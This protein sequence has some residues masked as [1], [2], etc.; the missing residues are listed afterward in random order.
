[1]LFDEKSIDSSKYVSKS[2]QTKAAVASKE[3]LTDESLTISGKEDRSERQAA[4]KSTMSRKNS[5]VPPE[6]LLEALSSQNSLKEQLKQALSLASTRSALILETETRLAEARGRIIS[7]EK[8]L[9]DRETQLKA[10]KSTDK[11]I[12]ER[13]EDSILSITI[14]SLQNLLLEKDTTLSKYQ[15]LLKA[16]RQDRTKEVETQAKEI[17]NLKQNMENL[18]EE[19]RKKKK[20]T[21]NLKEQS[22][23]TV[24]KLSLQDSVTTVKKKSSSES[25]D[26]ST[27]SEDKHQFSMHVLYKPDKRKRVEELEASVERMERQ[28]R[29]M[30]EREKIWEK[31]LV[32]LENENLK[33]KQQFQSTSAVVDEVNENI[34]Y[35]REIDRLQKLIEEKDCHIQ[36]LTETL[37]HFHDDQRNF[38]ADTDLQSTE[39]VTQLSVDLTRVEATNKVLKTQ[40]DAVK[41]QLSNVTMRESQA[42]ELIRNLKS[43][44]IRRPVISV[45]SERLMS[46]REDQLRKRNQQLEIEI[47]SLKDELKRQMTWNE[48]RRAKSATDLGL[49]EKQKRWQE[50]A[51]KLRDQLKI[52]EMEVERLQATLQ[53]AKNSVTRLE[54]EKHILEQRK[55]ASNYCTSA[56]CPNLHLVKATSESPESYIPSSATPDCGGVAAVNV[57]NES[58][59]ELV[60]ALK[61]RVEAQQRRIA[62]L[63]LEGR[64]Q[65]AMLA[66]ID[67]LTNSCM[68]LQ[69]QNVRL[70][71]RV[72]QLQLENTKLT[73]KPDGAVMQHQISHLEE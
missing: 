45:K 40:L 2:T 14:A 48:N 49:W 7:L 6:A 23:A 32:D 21:E 8:S 28:V 44:L 24:S 4:E 58:N 12:S 29:E 66:E 70:E 50:T 33:L 72:L 43:Q 73:E 62:A 38:M 19:L 60:E 61:S 54:R 15:E 25:A 47:D 63:E 31:N 10:A 27:S 68:E 13:K 39:Q 71:A 42:R 69:S 52:K 16:E 46:S 30:S 37:T 64:G 11:S 34:N 1:M 35:R 67:K 59:R 41:R 3:T 65:N 56:S 55:A 9:I 36:D 57:L 18:E 5:R 20:E 22:N 51:E 53:S 26:E 17:R